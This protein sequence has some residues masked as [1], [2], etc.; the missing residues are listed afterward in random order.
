MLAWRPMILTDVFHGF[1][2]PLQYYNL[3]HDC[4]LPFIF[5][6]IA[7]MFYD[8]LVHSPSFEQHCQTMS[9]EINKYI[10]QLLL[11]LLVH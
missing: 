2:L 5:Q 11:P 1:S 6:F 3:G 7:D 10:Y 4:V 8:L 9:L